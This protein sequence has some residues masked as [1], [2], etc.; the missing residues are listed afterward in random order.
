[1]FLKVGPN[2]GTL[3]FTLF[4]I[5]PALKRN[6][7]FGNL[8][9]ASNLLVHIFKCNNESLDAIIAEIIDYGLDSESD[10]ECYSKLITTIFEDRS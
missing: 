10:E 3:V 6:F 9:M 8:T 7:F 2:N 4:H 5:M 1:M